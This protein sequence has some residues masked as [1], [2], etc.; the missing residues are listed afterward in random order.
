MKDSFFNLCH[1]SRHSCKLLCCVSSLV[2]INTASF[3]TMMFNCKQVTHKKIF[4]NKLVLTPTENSMG[5]L[6]ICYTKFHIINFLYFLLYSFLILCYRMT[7]H[8]Q[9]LMPSL[10]NNMDKYSITNSLLYISYYI[11]YI[12]NR[13][14]LVLTK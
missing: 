6:I 13:T 7:C 1:I 8:A 9:N 11:S 2:L 4:C 3:D 12:H 10:T 5:N 14:L